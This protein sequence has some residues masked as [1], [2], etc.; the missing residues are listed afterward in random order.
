MQSS[1]L[2]DGHIVLDLNEVRAGPRVQTQSRGYRQRNES[3][4]QNERQQRNSTHTRLLDS[5]N[6]NNNS[7]QPGEETNQ[8]RPTQFASGLVIR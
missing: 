1:K 8:E 7:T 5:M 3:L 2:G 6:S 4:V